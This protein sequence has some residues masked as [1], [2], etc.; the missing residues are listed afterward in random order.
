MKTI[1][2]K[3]TKL[4]K[5]VGPDNMEVEMSNQYVRIKDRP[6]Q[7][8]RTDISGTN[9]TLILNVTPPTDWETN[10]Y[11]VENGVW[12]L[13]NHLEGL[14]FSEAQIQINKDY[15]SL[16][17]ILRDLINE[18]S[19]FNEPIL[20]DLSKIIRDSKTLFKNTKKDIESLTEANY[21]T[22]MVMS[23]AA[24]ALINSFNP[25]L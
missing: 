2:D 9:S 14:T 22:Y 15:K 12:V 6:D 10:K 16:R 8:Y 23:D 25:Y 19:M 17:T 5:W 3:V 4:S 1:I 20:N 11:R 7:T 21:S 18:T 13:S 24:R